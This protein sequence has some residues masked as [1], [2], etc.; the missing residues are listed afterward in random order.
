MKI[1]IEAILFK[2]QITGIPANTWLHVYKTTFIDTTSD[3]L[4]VNDLHV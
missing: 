1:V 4:G 2:S 3:T